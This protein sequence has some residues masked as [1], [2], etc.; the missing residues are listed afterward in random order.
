MGSNEEENSSLNTYTDSKQYKHFV[1]D[2]ITDLNSST[3]VCT[4]M[5]KSLLHNLNLNMDKL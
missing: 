4:L 2:N 1:T 5:R 3:Q